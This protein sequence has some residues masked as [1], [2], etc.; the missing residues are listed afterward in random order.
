MLGLVPG[1]IV[2]FVFSAFE[3]AAVDAQRAG[4]GG[5]VVRDGDIYPAMIVRVWDDTGLVN[6]KVVLDGPDAYWATSVPYD[7]AKGARSWHW[8]FDGQAARYTPD[9]VADP[10]PGKDA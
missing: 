3:A 2:Y 7:P 1:R 9:R 8:M 5:N 6:L 4:G 10:A